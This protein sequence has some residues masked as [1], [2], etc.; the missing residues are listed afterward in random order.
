MAAEAKRTLNIGKHQVTL[1]TRGVMRNGDVSKLTELAVATVRLWLEVAMAVERNER[2]L[3]TDAPES[4][5][6]ISPYNGDPCVTVE[7]SVGEFTLTVHSSY[8][9]QA[10]LNTLW[11]NADAG[12]FI[13]DK[14]AEKGISST[15]PA[16][17]PAPAQQPPQS[18]GSAGVRHIGDF[19]S[20]E[21]FLD[22]DVVSFNVVRVQRKSEDGKETFRLVSTHNGYPSKFPSDKLSVRIG[23]KRDMEA[24][25]AELEALGLQPGQEV[26]VNWRYVCRVRESDKINSRTGLTTLYFN[27]VRIETV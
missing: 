18:N 9:A 21:R 1:V 8:T 2:E 16:S 10:A 27:P 15:P 3:A 14:L 17:E 13:L 5:L 6:D 19:D 23:D 24:V 25:G 20:K 22:G 26:A 11:S 7:G 4:Q 12:A